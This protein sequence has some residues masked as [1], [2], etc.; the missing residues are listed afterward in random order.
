MA[1]VGDTMNFKSAVHGTSMFS[2]RML[3]SVVILHGVDVYLLIVLF[4]YRAVF[5]RLYT[6]A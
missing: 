4:D 3:T 6:L 2:I 1:M 5:R